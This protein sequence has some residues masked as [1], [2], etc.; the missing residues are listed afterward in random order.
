MSIYVVN[1][2]MNCF[3]SK[4]KRGKNEVEAERESRI[5]EVNLRWFFIFRRKSVQNYYI[6][7]LL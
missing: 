6:Q 4:K 7:T 5:T 3:F 2:M 1:N